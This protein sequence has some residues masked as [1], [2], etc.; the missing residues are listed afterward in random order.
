MFL[1]GTEARNQA[2]N[3]MSDFIRGK[4]FPFRQEISPFI[5]DSGVVIDWLYSFVFE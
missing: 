5:H 3:L 4:H 2:S 1:R